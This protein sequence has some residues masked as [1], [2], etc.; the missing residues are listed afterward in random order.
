MSLWF[1]LFGVGIRKKGY[2]VFFRIHMVI[3]SAP[4][5]YHVVVRIVFLKS[6]NLVNEVRNPV[7]NIRVNQVEK[8]QSSFGSS[9][10]AWIMT[11]R[12]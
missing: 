11:V 9:F 3:N 2:E 4:S 5:D 8:F 12:I 1:F 7:G 6:R 10:Q